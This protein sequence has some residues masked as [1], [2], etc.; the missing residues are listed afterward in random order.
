MRAFLAGCAAACVI[1]V[2]AALVLNSL[3][4]SSADV[5]KIAQYVRL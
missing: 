2:V 5:F 3:D 1:A 4:M